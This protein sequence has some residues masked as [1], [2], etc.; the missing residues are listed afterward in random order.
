MIG[1]QT[2]LTLTTTI[3]DLKSKQVPDV[4]SCLRNNAYESDAHLLN[5]REEHSFLKGGSEHFRCVSVR[6][7]S[8]YCGS[9]ISFQLTYPQ[10]GVFRKKQKKTKLGQS[11][12]LMHFF[13]A[14]ILFGMMFFFLISLSLTLF[15]SPD[16]FYRDYFILFARLWP[17]WP[18]G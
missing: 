16:H 14:L 8:L 2:D 13:Q 17:R 9:L 1:E 6:F 7:S 11:E 4:C 12:D 15:P 18:W 5:Q 10:A 3:R